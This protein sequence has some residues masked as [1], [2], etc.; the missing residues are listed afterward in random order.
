LGL[1]AAYMSYGNNEATA[2]NQKFIKNY[3][4]DVYT[5]GLNYNVLENLSVGVDVSRYN[6]DSTTIK[7]YDDIYVTAIFVF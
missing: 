6:P 7:S 5:L 2:T 1:K 3:D 4:Y